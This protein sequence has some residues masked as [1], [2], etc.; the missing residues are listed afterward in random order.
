M[1]EKYD[2]S[3]ICSAIDEL[4]NKGN[5]KNKLQEIFNDQKITMNTESPIKSNLYSEIPSIVDKMIL[6]AKKYLS[7]NQD[8][9]AI[10]TQK[11]D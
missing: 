4:N 6:E 5:K 11:E 3:L 1:D 8:M 9:P 2:M 7:L 10:V